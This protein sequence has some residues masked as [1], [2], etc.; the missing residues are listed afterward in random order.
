[1]NP[2]E[3]VSREEHPLTEVGEDFDIWPDE[4]FGGTDSLY[5]ELR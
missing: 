2:A 3:Y 4:R 5:D 1:M